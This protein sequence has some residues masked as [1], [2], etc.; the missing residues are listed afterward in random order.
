MDRWSTLAPTRP[1]MSE[2]SARAEAE[3]NGAEE[4]IRTSTIL[5][6]PALHPDRKAALT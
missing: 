1:A 3:S 5:R 6:S 4:R 2:A